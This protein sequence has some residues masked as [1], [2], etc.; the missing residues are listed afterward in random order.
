MIK[1]HCRNCGHE[2]TSKYQQKF[3]SHSCSAKIS[4]KK[5]MHTEET[6]KKI[7]IT[8]GGKGNITA[9][10]CLFCGIEL[11]RNCK[12]CSIKCQ[13]KFGQKIRWQNWE[14]VGQADTNNSPTLRNYLIYKFGYKCSICNI[15]TWNNEKV[16]LVL[17]HIDGNADS[18]FLNNIRLVCRNCDGLLPTFTGRNVGKGNSIN[19]S[20]SLC[21]TYSKRQFDPV[22]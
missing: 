19:R 14:R 20:K 22:G 18:R 12:F 9:K 13:H 4:N 16:P 17:D 7:S 3:C 1:K 10:V 15:E 2:L 6:R 21:K 5:R 11:N 8:L